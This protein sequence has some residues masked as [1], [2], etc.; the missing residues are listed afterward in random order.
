[1][2]TIKDTDHKDL[3]E[4]I[5]S[6]ISPELME[7]L[8]A[9]INAMLLFA[10]HNG[11]IINTE[12]NSLIKN[13]NNID[14]LIHAHNLLVKNVA[15]ATPKSIDFIKE[16]FKNDNGLSFFKKPTLIRNLIILTVLFLIFFIL[17][18]LSPKVNND[19]LAQGIMENHGVSLLLNIGFLTS[20]SGLGVMFYLLKNACLSIAKGSLMP[21]ETISYVAQI[22]LG[23]VSGIIIS[24]IIFFY[25]V[26][27]SDINL[28]NRCVLALIGGFSSDAIFS[29]I[30]GIV[31]RIKTIFIL[32]A[33]N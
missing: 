19:S 30:Q 26:K 18:A 4:T 10:I 15:P 5:R 22:I 27:P 33:N 25:T 2:D 31:D 16:T 20:I 32:E 8:N 14:D 24:E 28:I 7:K 11:I 13:N 29:I 1:M 6:S 23:I 17:T 9:E 3:P 12:I 21:E